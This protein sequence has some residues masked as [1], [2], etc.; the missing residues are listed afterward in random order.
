MHALVKEVEVHTMPF[1][2][3]EEGEPWDLFSGPDLYYE[4]YGPD[5]ALLHASEVISDVRPSDLPIALGGKFAVEQ[6]GPHVLRLLDADLA[7]KEVVGR[8][9]FDAERLAEKGAGDPP[10]IVRLKDRKTTLR[11]VIAWEE[12]QS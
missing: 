9:A 1:T 6:M 4:A 2:S 11:V 12:G 7:G 3:E 10:R 5:G 8:V